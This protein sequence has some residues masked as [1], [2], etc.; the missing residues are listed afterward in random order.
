M[1][2]R[3][4]KK[5][6]KIYGKEKK[7]FKRFNFLIE[8]RY[9]NFSDKSANDKNF[10]NRSWLGIKIDG[11]KKKFKDGGRYSRY[12]Y[13]DRDKFNRFDRITAKFYFNKTSRLCS[14]RNKN[15]EIASQ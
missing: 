14:T 10:E 8:K 1:I 13:V 15:K 12:R 3:K 5:E 2:L 4:F 6:R 11:L 7:I 9:I